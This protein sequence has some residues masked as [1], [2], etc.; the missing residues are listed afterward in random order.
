[1][2]ISLQPTRFPHDKAKVIF[3]CSYLRGAAFTWA[4]PILETIDSPQENPI[5]RNFNEFVH[6]LRA[7]FGD[8]DPII[9]AQRQLARLT[10]GNSPA[11]EYASTFQRFASQTQW[12]TAALKYHFIH[13]LSE[14][15][16]DE[17]STRD[18]PDDFEDFVS[19]IIAL[20]NNIRER[21]YYKNHVPRKTDFNNSR[22]YYD[23]HPNPNFRASPHMNMSRQNNYDRFRPHTL[24]RPMHRSPLNPSFSASTTSEPRTTASNSYPSTGVAPMDISVTRHHYSP[25]TIEERKRRIDLKLCLYC[26]QEGH[27]AK[28]CPVKFHRQSSAVTLNPTPQC[29]SKEPD[30]KK[31]RPQH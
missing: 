4:Q 28:A 8:P 7:A 6:R 30:T 14:E 10:Q 16:Q 15:L 23:R 18:M 3:L 2:V 9:T 21:R 20:D 17:I 22:P 13:G 25:L 5:L 11:S 26:G 29:S 1:M 19:R 27:Q 31:L 24:S 12:N